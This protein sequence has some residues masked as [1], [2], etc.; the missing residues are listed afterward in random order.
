MPDNPRIPIL[1]EAPVDEE[2]IYVTGTGGAPRLVGITREHSETDAQGERRYIKTVLHIT[3]SDGQLINPKHPNAY[4]CGICGRQFLS[5][6]TTRYCHGCQ[7]IICL[8]SC[9]HPIILED[10]SQG[11][12]CPACHRHMRRTNFIHFLF[13][14][15]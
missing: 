3:A 15:A 13:S 2:R 7:T 1:S 8:Q 4:D 6:Q 12:L 11:Y 14:I 5:E 10:N 9:A